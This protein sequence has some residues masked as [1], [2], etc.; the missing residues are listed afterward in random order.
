MREPPT[1]YLVLETDGAVV[2][3][4]SWQVVSEEDEAVI[5]WFVFPLQSLI[6]AM[7]YT[8]TRLF[9]EVGSDDN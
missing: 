8:S 2:G 7:S 1:R 3:F 9:K 6:P 4:V 5:Y